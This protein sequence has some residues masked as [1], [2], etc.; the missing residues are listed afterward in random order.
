[1]PTLRPRRSHYCGYHPPDQE[2]TGRFAIHQV[3]R[4][5]AGKSADPQLDCGRETLLIG[6]ALA[7]PCIFLTA[8]TRSEYLRKSH[9]TSELQTDRLKARRITY[10]IIEPERDNQQLNDACKSGFDASGCYPTSSCE[11][12]TLNG[13]KCPHSVP[14]GP[15][16]VDP[17]HQIK[18]S[19]EGSRS[20]RPGD[21]Q[22]GNPPTHCWIV[23][24]KPC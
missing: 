9:T 14:V 18:K 11:S 20:T 1:M 5:T 2:I 21:R 16:I 12:P 7:L 22:P 23:A 19:R 6:N 15:I 17:I 8:R 4:S 10:E 3:R 24:E 13:S